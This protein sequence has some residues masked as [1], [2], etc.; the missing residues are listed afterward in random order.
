MLSVRGTPGDYEMW[1]SITGD[2][3]WSPESMQ[4]HEEAYEAAIRPTIKNNAEDQGVPLANAWVAASLQSSLPTIKY[5]DPSVPRRGSFL[6]DTGVSAGV[7]SSTVR[8]YTLPRLLSGRANL[9]VVVNA[10]VSKINTSVAADGTVTAT[11]CTFEAPDGT[12]HVATAGSE[13]IL[14]AGAYNSPQILLL[15]GI[16]PKDELAGNG[17]ASVVDLPAVGKHL[18]DHPLVG[19]KVRLGKESAGFPWPST[20]T[21]L[22]VLGN[23]WHLFQY[24]VW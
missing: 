16:G 7:R 3:R 11:G 9:S 2:D 5:N 6:F 19:V 15:S 17:I 10:A 8:A 1:R 22:S 4:R 20:L 13:V 21:K 24:G 23:P 18:Q 14:S 12:V